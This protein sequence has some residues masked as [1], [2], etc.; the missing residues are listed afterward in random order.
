MPRVLRD[1]P[2]GVVVHAYNRGNSKARVFHTV[3]DYQ[4][5]CADLATARERFAIA[6]FAYC[7]MPNHWHVLASPRQEFALSRALHFVTFRHARRVHR[8]LGT[9]GTGHIFQDR[10]K[11]KVIDD[12]RYFLTAAR[13]VEANARR[14]GLVR[15]AEQ[16]EWSSASAKG[17]QPIDEWP[18]AKP[19]DWTDLLDA[20]LTQGEISTCIHQP[21]RP[22]RRRP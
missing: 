2:P 20:H 19:D 3:D 10:F 8:R 11:A 18:V 13:Y 22:G 15:R 21:K 17:H 5:F 4:G 14:A 9:T 16:W 1:V 6:V 12:E 7:L